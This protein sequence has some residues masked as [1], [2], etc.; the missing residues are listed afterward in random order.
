M[1]KFNIAFPMATLGKGPRIADLA[2]V[3]LPDAKIIT[4]FSGDQLALAYRDAAPNLAAHSAILVL[5]HWALWG[6]LTLAREAGVT[7]VCVDP[8]A[9]QRSQSLALA[10]LMPELHKVFE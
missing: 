5:D 2:T 7:Q 3:T 4:L 1:V 9:G 6:L 10:E 8:V